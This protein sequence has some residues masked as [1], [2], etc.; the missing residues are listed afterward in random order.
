MAYITQN[1][2]LEFL[3]V[4]TDELKLVPLADPVNTLMLTVNTSGVVG[5]QAIPSGGGSGSPAG[6]NTEIQY[7]SSGS[8]GASSNFTWD[9][10]NSILRIVGIP[11]IGTISGTLH[12]SWLTYNQA[13]FKEGGG[14]NGIG[15]MNASSSVGTRP[16]IVGQRSR[17]T[18]AT[19]LTVNDNDWLFGIVAGGF[20]G[21]NRQTP[22]AIEF[23]VDGTP[24]AGSLPARIEFLTGTAGGN[25]TT[26]LTIGS[27]GNIVIPSLD[28]DLTAPTTT[29]TTKM[30]ITDS[31]GL[32][33]FAD[34]PAGGGGVTDGDKGDIT[35]SASGATWTIDNGV[36]SLTK[37]SATGT[38]SATTYLR[39]DNSWAT[40]VQGQDFS[41]EYTTTTPSTPATGV[42]P[43]AFKRTGNTQLAYKGIRTGDPRPVQT[44]L[45]YKRLHIATTNVNA[46]TIHYVG[47]ITTVSTNGTPAGNTIATTNIRTS[48]RRLT[49]TSAAA[50]NSAA[51][52]R[53][54]QPYYWIGNAS[55]VGGFN[56]SLRFS[57][58]ALQT[59]NTFFAGMCAT[60]GT[61]FT[62]Q[63]PSTLT[64][65]F[66]VA[67]EAAD[68]TFYFMHNDGTST[69]IKSNT[70]ITPST[71]TVYVLRMFCESNGS[72]IYMSLEDLGSGTV[73]EYSTSTEI[74]ANTQLLCWQINHS[75]AAGT[76][77]V[78]VEFHEMIGETYN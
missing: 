45:Q 30:V 50:I 3:G 77:A 24:S 39:G 68:S 28:T 48:S 75:T 5:A 15:L 32:L 34:I 1:S 76:A 16:V 60:T 78:G 18:L 56:N 46:A 55:N 65:I 17:G 59:G 29:G 63:A 6:S 66:G 71:T 33:S 70:S 19:P 67:F 10:T 36:I 27:T 11:Y 4:S 20:E 52:L 44:S 41:T 13:M 51:G 69:A 38:P 22:A 62:S 72:T 25:R 61:L 47:Y 8:F 7:N 64:N 14:D 26:R 49:Y 37:L 40:I 12:S 31:N 9:N 43:Y 58:S 21:T 54:A 23:K 57:F 2:Y 74:P 42:T 35:V 53:S 73:A